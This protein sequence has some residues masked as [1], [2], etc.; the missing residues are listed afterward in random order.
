MTPSAG[1][2]DRL[3]LLLARHEALRGYTL[4][5]PTL[6]VVLAAMAVP[7]MLMV[8]YSFWSQSYVTLD[9]TLTLKNYADV[10]TRD[11]YHTLFLR[12][13]MISGLVTLITVLLAYPMAYFV[14][15][16]VKKHKL[17]WLILLTLPFWTSYLLR[18][19]SW[20]VILGYNGVINSGLMSL[21][22]IAEPLQFLLYNPFSV[23]VTL[24]H[25]WA[26][27]AI[28]PIYVSLEKIDRT[29]LEAATDLGD[30]P[31]R[32][33]FRVTLPL[34]MPGVIAASLLIF[35]PTVGDYVTPTLVGG[36]GGV[37]IANIIQ[38]Q[39]GKANNWPLGSALAISTM[40]AVTAIA[41]LTIWLAKRG[42]GAI[43]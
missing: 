14:A 36:T 27:F 22:V 18:V 31:V 43:R 16:D 5:S 13:V 12:S 21:G 29:L 9:T 3:H 40:L 33:F 15:F 41:C 37:M 28:L 1:L 6:F 7:L 11:I 19:F 34:S 39:F 4:I 2:L 38:A 24:A 26:A 10:A 32:R 42:T 23:I 25:A 17:L 20:K 35:I 30:G 8:A